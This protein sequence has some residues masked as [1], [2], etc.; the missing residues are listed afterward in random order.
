MELYIYPKENSTSNELRK[1]I[2]ESLNSNATTWEKLNRTITENNIKFSLFSHIE[3]QYKNEPFYFRSPNDFVIV[4][5][6][7]NED[8]GSKSVIIGKLVYYLRYHLSDDINK[9]EIK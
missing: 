4:K 8:E 3:D 6:E 5:F 2:L 7:K 9:I 1:T